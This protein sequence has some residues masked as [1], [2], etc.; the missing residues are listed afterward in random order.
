MEKLWEFKYGLIAISE[1][2]SYIFKCKD[3]NWCS[4]TFIKVYMENDKLFGKIDFEFNLFGLGLEMR[5]IYNK[6]KHDRKTKQLLR[7]VRDEGLLE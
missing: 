4:F 1:E 3:Y 6:K 2:Y 7:G 5:Y